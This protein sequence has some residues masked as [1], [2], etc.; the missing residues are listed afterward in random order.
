[1]DCFN[2]ST[3][4]WL[5]E[6]HFRF[7]VESKRIEKDTLCKQQPKENCHDCMKKDK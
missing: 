6:Q 3:V 2:E 4:Y 5:Q 1:M 7:K